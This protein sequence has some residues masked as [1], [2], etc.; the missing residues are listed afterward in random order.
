MWAQLLWAA[1]VV[2]GV[3]PLA[4][5]SA[6]V[7]VSSQKILFMYS[8]QVWIWFFVAVAFIASLPALWI[9]AMAFWP[10]AARNWRRGARKSLLGTFLLGLAPVLVAFIV[11]L[12]MS[13]QPKFGALAVVFAAMVL[14]WGFIGAAGLA[15]RVGERMWPGMRGTEPWREIRNGGLVLVCSA[16][17]PIVGWVFV[18][19]VLSILG[20]GLQ[21]RGWLTREPLAPAP[22]AAPVVAPSN[23]V[24]E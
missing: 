22:L 7:L 12:A 16:L 15:A 2:G 23:A 1:L 20:M 14:G 6:R 5:G 4:P 9:A 11:V 13:K 8:A 17:L 24:P 10:Q 21:V 19:P 3:K 18:L